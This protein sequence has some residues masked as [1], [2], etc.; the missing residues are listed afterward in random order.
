MHLKRLGKKL[1]LNIASGLFLQN[2]NYYNIVIFLVAGGFPSGQYLLLT[3]QL[4]IHL[5]VKDGANEID[6]VINRAAALEQNW[7]L[8]LD[9]VKQMKRA[10]MTA[11][12]KII[13]A[14]GEL[15]SNENIYKTSFAAML[16]GI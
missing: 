14:T 9:E 10:S 15:A 6:A 11:C 12:L 8:V 2:K 5:A 3:R 13:L 4:E 1:T 7:E 16:A